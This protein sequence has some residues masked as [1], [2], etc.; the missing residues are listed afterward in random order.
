MAGG[1][2]A[3]LVASVSYNQR[4]GSIFMDLSASH[5]YFLQLCG[6]TTSS[7]MHAAVFHDGSPL[8]FLKGLTH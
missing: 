1:Y 2:F 8:H 7:T 6:I 5:P 3:V 4:Y